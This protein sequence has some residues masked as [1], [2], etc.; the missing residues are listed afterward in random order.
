[1]D[2]KGVEWVR[3]GFRFFVF[4]CEKKR[5]VGLVYGSM[6]WMNLLAIALSP[7]IVYHTNCVY[8]N[9]EMVIQQ[10]FALNQVNLTAYL[11]LCQWFVVQTTP[12][13]KKATY[14][15]IGAIKSIEQSLACE[16]TV[17][18]LASIE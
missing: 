16:T 2:G 15:N 1:M 7:A 8:F 18:I 14:N 5:C 3:L 9:E 17:G 6:V 12:P 10:F 4:Y 13:I 11:C